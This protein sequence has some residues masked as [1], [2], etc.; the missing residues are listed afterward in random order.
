MNEQFL[1]SVAKAILHE[2][3]GI[4]GG[5]DPDS[6]LPPHFVEALRAA[7]EKEEY[8]VRIGDTTESTVHP[9]FQKILAAYTRPSV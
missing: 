3:D 6:Y 5:Y 8:K 2:V 1:L 9:L 4:T 7:I